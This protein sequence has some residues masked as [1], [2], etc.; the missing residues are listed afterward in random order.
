M[1]NYLAVIG[2]VFLINF[3]VILSY[4]KDKKP[5]IKSNIV[6][7]EQIPDFHFQ[8]DVE[9]EPAQKNPVFIKIPVFRKSEIDSVYGDVLSHSQ[10]EPFGDGHGRSTNVHETSHSIHSQIR[11]S[12]VGK[13]KVNGFYLLNGLGVIIEEPNVK[14]SDVAAR[15]PESLRSYR[16]NLYMVEQRKDWENTP[17]YILDE[18]NAYILGAMCCVDDVKKGRHNNNWSDGVSGSLDFSFYTIVFAMTVFELD[19]KFWKDNVQFKNFIRWNL[20]RANQVYLSGCRMD[21]FQWE[22]QDKLLLNFLENKDSEKVRIFLKEEL[23]GI[24]LDQKTSDIAHQKIK[25]K[26]I[27]KLLIELPNSIENQ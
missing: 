11:N 5:S 13:N 9:K 3:L 10:E 6:I 16:Y 2:L 4:S 22:Q 23:D 14:I 25:Y 8:P 20:V 21:Q 12:Y 17:T 18:W 7:I 15:T 27:Q 24:W 19:Q 26:S 1:R